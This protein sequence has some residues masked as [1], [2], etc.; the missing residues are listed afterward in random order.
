M[1]LGPGQQHGQG[2]ARCPHLSI[3]LNLPLPTCLNWHILHS[4]TF[5]MYGSGVP[6]VRG[7]AT[8]LS[9]EM[10]V[11]QTGLQ[12]VLGRMTCQVRCRASA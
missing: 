4:S 8:P 11:I 10:A 2:A 7:L 12:L 6:H 9:E 1:N 3:P 5:D